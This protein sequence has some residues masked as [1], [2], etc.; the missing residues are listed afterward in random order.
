MAAESWNEMRVCLSRCSPSSSS[1]NQVMA[2]MVLE[3]WER[4]F[5]LLLLMLTFQRGTFML[6]SQNKPC[7]QCGQITVLHQILGALSSRN[8]PS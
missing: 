5:S 2:R 3:L 4:G 6:H 7:L 1:W 8:R